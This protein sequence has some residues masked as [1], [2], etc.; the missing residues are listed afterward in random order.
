MNEDFFKEKFYLIDGAGSGIGQATAIQLT[1]LGARVA[2][3]D[4]NEEGLNETFSKLYGVGH[5]IKP[6][7]LCD[8]DNIA[9]V[10][11]ELVSEGGPFNGFVHCVG[12]RCR[13]P[14]KL[15]SPNIF[16]DIIKIN[17]GSF[18][19][20]VRH[21]SKKNNYSLGLSIVGIS[22]V[23][24]LMSGA[25]IMAYAASKAALDGVVRSLAKELAQKSIRINS[26]MPGQINTQA[27]SRI[28]GDGEDE[29]LNRQYL[30]LGEPIDV[31]ATIL[32]LLSNN[33]RMITGAAIPV[34]GGFLT[35]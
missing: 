2:L 12:V 15:L 20:I 28:V 34:D 13:R 7:D 30:G 16:L 25:G 5:I 29:V 18:V 8:L 35:F 33:S 1:K 3:V 23:S 10:I 32:F 31:V 9:N 6:V 19:E 21:I 14:L 26:V 22:S 17:V 27:Y 24:S 11:K 4:V